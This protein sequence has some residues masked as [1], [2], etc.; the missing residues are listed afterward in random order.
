MH[1]EPRA[2]RLNENHQR[3]WLA[4]ARYVDG[5]L[6]EIELILAGVQSPF[7]RYL[8]DVPADRKEALRRFAADLRQALVRAL[9]AED[10]EPGLPTASALHTI[11]TDINFIDTAIEELK[12][13]YLRGYGAVPAAAAPSI[14]AAVD[15]LQAMVRAIDRALGGRL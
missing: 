6:S 13:R 7:A 5:L 15:R 9:A 10:V 3:R 2:G 4:T 11:R 12:P 14:E 1:R 8:D